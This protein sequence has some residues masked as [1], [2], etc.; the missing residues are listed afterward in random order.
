MHHVAARDIA[1][2]YGYVR[3]Y[4]ARLCR[5]GKVRGRQLGTDWYVDETSFKNYF[6]LREHE[7]AARYQRIAAERRVEYRVAQTAV[8]ENR[9][10]A[11]SQK[12]V[13]PDASLPAPE[14]GALNMHFFGL[15]IHIRLNRAPR[16]KQCRQRLTESY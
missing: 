7:R 1:R 3:E 9:S 6:V 12:S 10:P 4:V 15:C 16:P 14:K 11:V 8:S 5:E 2:K 13:S